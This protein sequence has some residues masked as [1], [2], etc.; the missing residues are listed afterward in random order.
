MPARQPVSFGPEVRVTSHANVLGPGNPL[1]AR[2]G[3]VPLSLQQGALA[4]QRQGA[5]VPAVRQR[6]ARSHFGE[7]PGIPWLLIGGAAL[8]FF[9]FK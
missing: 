3:A 1:Y 9:L 8:L 6:G 7:P 4:S 5:V 2:S